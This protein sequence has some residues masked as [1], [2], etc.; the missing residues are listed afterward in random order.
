MSRLPSTGFANAAKP[1]CPA[2]YPE[3]NRYIPAARLFSS[4]SLLKVF[5]QEGFNVQSPLML[6]S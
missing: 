6:P 1:G 5:V 4:A 3:Q 2:L